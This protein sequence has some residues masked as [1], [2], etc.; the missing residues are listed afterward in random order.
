MP[1]LV[2]VAIGSTW[3]SVARAGAIST[4]QVTNQ[5]VESADGF[6]GESG[7]RR[8]GIVE[9]QAWHVGHLTGDRCRTPVQLRWSAARST[10]CGS[11]F[12]REPQDVVVLAGEE[13]FEPSIS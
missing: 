3:T 2:I 13:G 8:A 5:C 9:P 12:G 10:T 1:V 6:I 4:N 11:D 7:D